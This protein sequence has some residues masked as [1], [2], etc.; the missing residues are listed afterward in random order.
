M[1]DSRNKLSGNNKCIFPSSDVQGSLKH[2]QNASGACTIKDNC[3][4]LR[5]ILLFELS[6]ASSGPKGVTRHSMLVPER[7][8]HI[9]TLFTSY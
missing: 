3:A 6:H 5:T 9:F 4:V 2:Q 7:K 1:V 8:L